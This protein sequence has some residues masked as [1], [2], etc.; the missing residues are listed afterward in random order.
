[1]MAMEIDR[2]QLGDRTILRVVF[3]EDAVQR[4]VRD[5]A[6]RSSMRM[7]PRTGSW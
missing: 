3:D 1:M 2:A 5:L 4:R 7:R 6:H